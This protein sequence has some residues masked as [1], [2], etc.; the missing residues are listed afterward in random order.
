[1]KKVLKLGMKN[2]QQWPQSRSV[3]T[4]QQ[5]QAP[6]ALKQS[7]LKGACVVAQKMAQNTDDEDKQAPPRI[8]DDRDEYGDFEGEHARNSP[9]KYGRR[10]D[11][12]ASIFYHFY[13]Y[14]S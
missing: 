2:V 9:K 12:K 14:S 7:V 1:M 4:G 11:S 3:P 8:F 13:K 6:S 10:A 5:L